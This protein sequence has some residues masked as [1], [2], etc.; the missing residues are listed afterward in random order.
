MKIQ[1]VLSTD[2]AKKIMAA[3]LHVT[4]KLPAE[5]DNSNVKWTEYGSQVTVE[6]SKGIEVEE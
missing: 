6:Y 2:E 4:F 5:F 1:L 3:A